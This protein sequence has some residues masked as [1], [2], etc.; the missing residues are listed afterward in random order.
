MPVPEDALAV[1][2]PTFTARAAIRAGLSRSAL[3]RLKNRGLVVELTRGVYRAADA[4]ETAHQDLLAVSVHVP[5]AVV[6]AVSALALHEL[7]DEIPSAV[8]FAV[9]RSR[10]LPRLRYPPTEFLRFDVATFDLGRM[11]FRVAPD[12]SVSVYGPARSVVDVMRLRHRFG[13]ALALQ[14]LRRY[15]ARSGSRPGELVSYARQLRVEGPVA[16]AVDVVLS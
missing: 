6:C 16:R 3:Q 5:R 2:P 1:L 11:D 14:A 8:Q 15:L 4:P 7:T 9:P 10:N 12:E 13:E